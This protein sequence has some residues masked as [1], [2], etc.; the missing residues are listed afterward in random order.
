MTEQQ[1]VQQRID[2]L[3]S[4]V[5]TTEILINVAKVQ[6]NQVCVDKLTEELYTLESALDDEYEMLEQC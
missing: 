5:E 4:Q 1:L 2:N 6:K 3:T